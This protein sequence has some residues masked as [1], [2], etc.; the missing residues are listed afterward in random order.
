MANSEKFRQLLENELKYRQG[1]R[2]GYSIRYFAKDLGLEHTFLAKVLNGTRAV[3][4][5]IIQRVAPQLGFS[6]ET[7]RATLTLFSLPS[8]ENHTPWIAK[9]LKHFHS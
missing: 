6:S 5:L 1:R 8:F 3:T 9:S 7:I 2:N 4:P